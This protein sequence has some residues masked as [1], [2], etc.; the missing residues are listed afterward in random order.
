MQKVDIFIQ[1]LHFLLM[2]FTLKQ[3]ECDAMKTT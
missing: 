3:E 1:I 2:V